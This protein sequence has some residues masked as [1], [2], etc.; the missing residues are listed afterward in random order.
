MGYNYLTIVTDGF[1]IVQRAIFLYI[2]LRR[3]AEPRIISRSL[4]ASC[5]ADSAG[6]LRLG[7]L[8]RFEEPLPVPA[9][10][11]QLLNSYMG[12]HEHLEETAVTPNYR[13]FPHAEAWST[14]KS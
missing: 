12:Q 8:G 13:Q 11:P 10:I 6:I 1:S 4:D 9:L 7:S 3:S 14:A 2:F 5:G